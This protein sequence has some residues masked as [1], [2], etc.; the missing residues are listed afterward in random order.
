MSNPEGYTP[1][2]I[3]P[4]TDEARTN[5]RK[6]GIASGAAR[7][8]RRRVRE[9]LEAVLSAEFD[10]DGATLTGAEKVAAAMIRRACEGDV[11]AAEFIRDTVGEKPVE[12]AMISTPDFEQ[13]VREE[14]LRRD[15]AKFAELLEQY[16][17][18]E[19]Q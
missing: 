16:G 6:G 1:N 7:R 5:G 14:V 15:Q 17:M 18:L 4:S 8:E 10:H 2:L 3:T 13:A 19:G 12:N 11:R 9:A